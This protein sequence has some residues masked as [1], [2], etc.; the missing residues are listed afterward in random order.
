MENFEARLKAAAIAPHFDAPPLRDLRASRPANVSH[1]Q[2]QSQ[3]TV[4]QGARGTCWAF[5]GC[6]ALEAAYARQNINVKLSEHYLFHISKAH[7]NHRAGPGIHSLIGFQGSSD[8]VH[9]LKY[10]RVPIQSSAPYIDQPALQALA[11]SIPGTGGALKNAGAGTLEQDD[12]FE[13]DLRNIPLNALWF[14]QYAVA[15]FG[16]NSNFTVDNLKDTIAAG[17]DIVVDVFDKINNGGHVLLIYGYDDGPQEF[18]IKNS[19][20]LPGFGRMKYVNDAQ[21][22]LLTGVAYYVK[23]AAPVQTQWAAMWAGRWEIDH[24]GLARHDDYPALP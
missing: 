11:D 3:F 4:G 23:S 20:S 16:T 1:Q 24:D 8:V 7:E 5:A 21:F 10:W 9:H 15:E 2:W 12:W 17:Y 19:Q 22:Q 6:A 14:A 18:L 13:F